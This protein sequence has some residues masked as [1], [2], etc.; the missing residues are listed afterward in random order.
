MAENINPIFWIAC[1][2]VLQDGILYYFIEIV[3]LY[4]KIY[5]VR[6]KIEG[7]S[8]CG[9]LVLLYSRAK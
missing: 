6:V 4:V 7:G 2:Y 5:W 8:I 3:L 1:F 9:L